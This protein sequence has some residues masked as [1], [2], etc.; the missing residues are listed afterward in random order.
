M[1][2]DLRVAPRA[3]TQNHHGSFAIG[4]RTKNVK[5]ISCVWEP[6]LRVAPCAQTQDDNGR[7]G[8]RIAPARW[9]GDAPR[10][11][12]DLREAPRAQT[13]DNHGSF[14]IGHR[15]KNVKRI[16]CVCPRRLGVV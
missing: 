15:T 6:D 4:H 2:P 5:R 14:A 13:Q 12:P 7:C 16:S 3:Q 8:T 1:E 11:E 9:S 10:W